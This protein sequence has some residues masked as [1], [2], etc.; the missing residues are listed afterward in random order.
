VLFIYIVFLSLGQLAAQEEGEIIIISERVGKEIDQEERDKFELF[1][2]INGFQSAVYIRLPDNR[3]FLEITYLDEKRGELKIARIQQSEISIE[4][5]E[6]YIDRFEEIQE[7]KHQKAI[8]DTSESSDI[9]EKDFYI[10]LYLGESTLVGNF[11]IEFQYK[12]IGYNIGVFQDIIAIDNSLCGGI[13]YYFKPHHH[14]W[15]IGI[16]GGIALDEPKP[17]DWVGEPGSVVDMYIGILIGYRWIWWN[18]LHL[19]IGAG[20]NYIKWK[21]IKEGRNADYLPML[22]FVIGYSF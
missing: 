16:G 20:P 22:D 17:D 15:V 8:S 13:R 7:K 9:K 6:Y 5:G 3:Y 10:T 19:N 11:G 18:K 4:N 1:Q 12:R 21:R 2:G 14:S